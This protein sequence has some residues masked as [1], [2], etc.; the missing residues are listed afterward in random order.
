MEMQRAVVAS[1]VISCG[2]RRRARLCTR[3]CTPP[4]QT[5]RGRQD[6]HVRSSVFDG[7][8]GFLHRRAPAPR[9]RSTM[10]VLCTLHP[11]LQGG[12]CCTAGRSSWRSCWPA[13]QPGV[14]G[15]RAAGLAADGGGPTV[16]I[17]MAPPRT[18]GSSGLSPWTPWQN[19]ACRQERLVAEQRAA[20]AGAGWRRY[21]MPT[22]ADRLVVGFRRWL[23][24]RGGGGPT[25]GDPGP[26]ETRREVLLDRLHQHTDNCPSCR[27]ARTRRRARRRAA[28]KV[29]R[30]AG[31]VVCRAVPRWVVDGRMLGVPHKAPA[32]AQPG[33]ACRTL[34]S[35]CTP[36]SLGALLAPPVAARP[37]G[38]ARAG[39]AALQAAAD[40]GG[41]R[42]GGRA[43]ERVRGGGGWA[44]GPVPAAAGAA[45]R[46]G[47]GGGRVHPARR[48]YS[49]L[50]LHKLCACGSALTSFCAAA[51]QSSRRPVASGGLAEL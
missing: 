34:T 35:Y 17:D 12:P 47:R 18:R 46:S 51:V 43:A 1:V 50:C 29:A 11:C 10:Q 16:C 42:A 19:P 14:A 36:A 27:Q 2:D 45:A 8:N 48:A 28:S 23:D 4:E 25:P 49:A 39:A 26:V 15:G 7:D 3:C 32:L 9:P 20:D 40:C 38:G 33:F 21:F 30:C 13:A 22:A 24:T 31:M 6:H 44:A 37:A 41:G 5:S